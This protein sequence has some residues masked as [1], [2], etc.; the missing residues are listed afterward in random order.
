MLLVVFVYVFYRLG[1]LSVKDEMIN[2]KQ[3]LSTLIERR[4]S[5]RVEIPKK[6]QQLRK[7]NIIVLVIAALLLIG[8]GTASYMKYKPIRRNS[9][10]L[11]TVTLATSIITLSILHIYKYFL[12]KNFQ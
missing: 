12:T 1:R 6:L 11:S 5:V 7:L 8:I 4:L 10:L 2:R 9:T 3:E